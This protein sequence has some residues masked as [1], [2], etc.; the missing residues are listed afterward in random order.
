MTVSAGSLRERHHP[1]GQRF[2]PPQGRIF[3]GGPMNKT[4]I[5]SVAGF[6]LCSLS[7]TFCLRG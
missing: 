2:L 1:V 5:L 3:V 7:L 6:A 4:F